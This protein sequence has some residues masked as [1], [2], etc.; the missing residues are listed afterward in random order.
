[1]MADGPP[2]GPAR[3]VAPAA[4]QGPRRDRM[5][6][7]ERH[8]RQNMDAMVAFRMLTFPVPPLPLV[9]NQGEDARDATASSWDLLASAMRCQLLRPE[10]AALDAQQR[11]AAAKALVM[12]SVFERTVAV[13]EL[14]NTGALSEAAALD[15]CYA[16]WQD[17]FRQYFAFFPGSADLR[18]RPLGDVDIGGIVHAQ[19][20]LFLRNQASTVVD[21]GGVLTDITATSGATRTY[22]QMRQR[23][24]EELHA[25]AQEE[26]WF[27]GLNC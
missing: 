2:P 10:E 23:Y 1:M 20:R 9:S 22:P 19:T 5:S 24:A 27:P 14:R 18:F 16:V 21:D 26:L 4:A 12:K 13:W 15:Q 6:E 11:T 25:Q 7:P 17:C 8:C 3:T